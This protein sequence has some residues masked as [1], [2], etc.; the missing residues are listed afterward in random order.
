MLPHIKQLEKK[1]R[2]Y[3]LSMFERIMIVDRPWG[4]RGT[5]IR[6]SFEKLFTLW[7]WEE[8]PPQSPLVPHHHSPGSPKVV[9]TNLLL[10]SRYV[11]KGEI[12]DVLSK[13]EDPKEWAEDFSFPYSP[14]TA[15]I[16]T[17]TKKF[18]K[19]AVW[20]NTCFNFKRFFFANKSIM[21]TKGMSLLASVF[22]GN[23]NYCP[24]SEDGVIPSCLVWVEIECM[25][26]VALAKRPIHRFQPVQQSRQQKLHRVLT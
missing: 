18:A 12:Q 3:Q 10:F 25:V 2:L 26:H 5:L 13:M 16:N 19:I 15:R 20:W 24:K 22:Q 9:S 6:F 14:I 17:H 1:E 21:N 4:K 11:L 23:L 8:Q 7:F